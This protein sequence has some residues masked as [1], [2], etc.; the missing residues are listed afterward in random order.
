MKFLA[1]LLLALC[2]ALAQGFTAVPAAPAKTAKSS[3]VKLNVLSSAIVP[4][5]GGV[6]EG[7][8]LASDRDRSYYWYRNGGYGGYYGGYPFIDRRYGYDTYGEI[9]NPRYYGH[10]YYGGYGG[11][12]GGGYGRYYDG[13][14]GRRRDWHGMRLLGG[15]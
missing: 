3:S 14:Y 6:Y 12:Y 7:D 10:G 15:Y 4:Y 1:L 13:F 11:Y 9:W 8:R 2:A 5:Y